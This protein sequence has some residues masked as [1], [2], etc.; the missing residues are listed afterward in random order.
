MHFGYAQTFKALY[1]A[2][3]VHPERVLVIAGIREDFVTSGAS[4]TWHDLALYLT[5]RQAGATTAQDVARMF[6]LQWHQ[7]GLAL[8]IVFEGETDHGD[9]K[10]LSAQEWLSRNFSVARPVD[11]MIKRSKIAERTFKRRLPATTGLT[12]TDYVATSA[13][14]RREAPS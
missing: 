6:A 7:D 4:T 14:R 9:G 2:I 8:Y 5:A 12:P 3:T 13:H 10:I 11:E 1:P